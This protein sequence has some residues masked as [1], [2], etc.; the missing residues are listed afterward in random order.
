MKN[1]IKKYIPESLLNI[2]R[3]IL[4]K[5]N[6]R[7]QRRLINA[8]ARRHGENL[9]RLQGKETIKVAFFAIHS[10][11]WKYDYLY[12][13]MV[14]HP[15]FEPVIVVCPVVNY[16]ME[17]M[18]HEMDRCYQMFHS[19]N[20]NVIRTYNV[21][22]K[23]YLDV[24]KEINPDI[25]FYT[26]PYKGLIDDRYYITNFPDTLTCYVSYNYGNSCLYD[27]FHNLPMHNL[28]W[29]LYAE[30]E[31][32]KTYSEK[33]ADN[34]GINVVV[35]G[36]PGVDAFLDKNYAVNDPW[37]IKDSTLKRLIWAPHHTIGENELVSYSCFLR[38]ADFML[39]LANKYQDRIQVAF[40]PHPLLR[41]KLNNY[42]GEEKTTQYYEEWNKIPNGFLA[43]GDYIDLFLTSDAMIHDSG[44][45]ITEYLYTKNPVMRTDNGIDL[46][47]E[48]N[49]FA[50]DCL[51]VY[52]HGKNENEIESF[53]IN[54]INGE[55]ALE[56]SRRHFYQEKLLP[57]NSQWASYNILN[58][59]LSNIN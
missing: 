25:I 2:R 7:V 55:D 42:W 54:L 52:Y 1:T 16:G 48:F 53:I 28:V 45:F 50:L 59:I 49:T 40:K 11:V 35:T 46:S 15:R 3:K 12:R 44:S 26:N 14:E 36:Y 32:H 37:K 22:S 33:Y 38:Y 23:E 43:D 31:C 9:K 6:D 20:Y 18:L 34:K 30:T 39:N 4:A 8:Q 58:D 13:L 24:K 57:P 56:E 47:K 5:K 21:E 19:R 29:R 41:V 17:N 10:S 27:V 51:S